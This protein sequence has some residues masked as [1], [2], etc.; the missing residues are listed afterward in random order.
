[1]SVIE[2]WPTNVTDLLWITSSGCGSSNGRSGICESVDRVF[3]LFI[4]NN[5]IS[6]KSVQLWIQFS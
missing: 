6:T 4:V 2:R 1:M 5:V 3:F